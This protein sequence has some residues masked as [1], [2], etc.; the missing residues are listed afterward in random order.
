MRTPST[1]D[2]IL[3]AAD[4]RTRTDEPSS[5]FVPRVIAEIHS[6]RLRSNY[7][8]I[9][10][11]NPGQGMIPM[12]K[13]NAYGHGASWAAR[14]LRE[15]PSLYALGVASLEEG[16]EIREALG[17]KGRRTSILVFSGAALW[18]DEKGNF[19]VRHGLT[20]VIST[21]EDWSAFQGRGWTSRLPYELKFNT[22]M[23]RLGLSL[24]NLQAVRKS[25]LKL[26]MEER[27]RG[28]LSHL[29]MAE[30]PE[31]KLS[32][33]QLARFQ[34]LVRELKPSLPAAQFHLANSSAIWNAKH[35]GLTELTD[36]VRPGISLYGVAPWPGAPS[37]GLQAVLELRSQVVA[38]H[39]LR[40]GE[41]VGYGATFQVSRS[42]SQKSQCVAILPVGYADGM[43]RYTS[44]RGTAVLEGREERFL[45]IVSMDLSAISCTS[46]TRPG[47]PVEILGPHTDI[48][49]QAKNA[50]TLP[51][52]LL[53]SLSGRV[54]RI[55]V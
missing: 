1:R 26:S 22:G 41:G 15:L 50:G 47:A 42:G 10:K 18:S 28:I 34:S 23:N 8:A 39:E 24:G 43:H 16:A 14:T 9:Q 19:C 11:L 6:S 7:D 30:S 32:R 53:T 54:Q 45:G 31:S 49:E 20:P 27:P 12:I 29:A 44:N 13:A 25:L 51:Y 17:V 3:E 2:R 40:P 33:E 38:V 37:R 36:V 52:E 5:D 48:W 4:R 35:F 55:Y 21:D 46:R